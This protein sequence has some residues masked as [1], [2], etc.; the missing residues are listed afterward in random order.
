MP[1]MTTRRLSKAASAPVP[2]ATSTATVAPVI[3]AAPYPGR[4]PRAYNA[5][6]PRV[7]P[8]HTA[9]PLVPSVRGRSRVR[10]A[11]PPAVPDPTLVLIQ[12][13]SSQ[14]AALTGAVATVT[15]DLTSLRNLSAQP[16]PTSSATIVA[17]TATSPPTPVV[18]ATH[19]DTVSAAVSSAMDTAAGENQPTVTSFDARLLG[20]IVDVKIKT[21]IWAM[22]YIDMADL[23]KASPQQEC[24]FQFDEGTLKVV[25]VQKDKLSIGQ[26]RQAFD[27]Y[28]S[29]MGSSPAKAHLMPPMLFYKNSVEVMHFRFKGVA[30]RTYDE[31]FRRGIAQ[32]GSQMSWSQ[33]DWNRYMD[34]YHKHL[35]GGG[36]QSHPFP[37][38]AGSSRGG[39]GSQSSPNSKPR[40]KPSCPKGYCYTFS[41]GKKCT[42]TSCK[43]THKCFHC[44]G[45]HYPSTCRKPKP[46]VTG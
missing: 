38:R 33:T 45:T 25:P 36:S 7:T 5:R 16:S 2:D 30:W 27:T 23:I 21:K 6:I 12:Q 11:A 19:A 34:A 26:W 44:E 39:F 28:I 20:D 40:S 32:P 15:S 37:S 4:P 42:R 22:E 3:S 8:T 46:S 43:F 41:D 14:V 1:S 24:T 35:Q 29:I 18:T 10:S 31:A 13:L 9:A 17:S